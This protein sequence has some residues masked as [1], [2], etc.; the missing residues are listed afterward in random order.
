VFVFRVGSNIML[1]E[2][3]AGVFV[4][5]G[6]GKTLPKVGDTPPRLRN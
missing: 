1:G 3:L 5:A 6:E 2:M 4:I